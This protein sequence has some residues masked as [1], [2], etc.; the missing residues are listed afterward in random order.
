M[1]QNILDINFNKDDVRFDFRCH[2][3]NGFIGNIT[4]SDFYTHSVYFIWRDVLFDKNLNA[5]IVPVNEKLK[6]VISQSKDYP[7]FNFNIYDS[8]MRLI[9]L[10]QFPI[11]KANPII[12]HPFSTPI[13]DIVAPSYLDF[14]YSNLCTNMDFS[15]IVVDGGANVGFFTLL[16]KKNGAKRI[17]AIEPDPSTFNCLFQNFLF[18][19]NVV[20]INKALYQELTTLR[21]FINTKSSVASSLIPSN[22]SVGI[23]END[24]KTIRVGDILLLEQ[25]INLLKLDI[26]GSEYGVLDNILDE[27]FSRINQIFVEFHNGPN[28]I[29]EKLTSVGYICELRDCD[30]NSDVGF[31][32]ARK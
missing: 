29:L 8:D 18:D 20:L 22:S 6:N 15:G 10:Y 19:D 30:M 5:W 23:I 16:S 21:F 24:V 14:F 27:E 28:L 2:L 31:I 4:V 9:E 7:G 12:N 32:Y 13:N 11:N 25:N 26:E 3:E 1:M 17:Y